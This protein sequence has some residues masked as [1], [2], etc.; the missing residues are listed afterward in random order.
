MLWSLQMGAVPGKFSSVEV[1]A[2]FRGRLGEDVRLKALCQ[3]FRAPVQQG[4]KQ[5]SGRKLQNRF[6]GA[7]G[8]VRGRFSEENI[9][10]VCFFFL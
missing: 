8:K 1:L 7:S 5:N 3:G 9:T 6:E 4:S 10:W 2:E